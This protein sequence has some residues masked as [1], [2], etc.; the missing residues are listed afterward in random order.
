M[1]RRENPQESHSRPN[2]PDDN[3]Q[4]NHRAKPYQ[5]NH[6]KNNNNNKRKSGSV[7][8]PSQSNSSNGTMFQTSFDRS[9]PPYERHMMACESHTNIQ[10]LNLNNI[11]QFADLPPPLAV[12][13]G[14]IHMEAPHDP[15]N[16]KY[17]VQ[18][19]VY[20]PYA[21]HVYRDPKSERRMT[22]VV[23]NDAHRG[24]RERV[25]FRP[26]PGKILNSS[27]KF[28]ELIPHV[29]DD[30][31]CVKTISSDRRG[32]WCPPGYQP[33]TGN[34]YDEIVQSALASIK[35]QWNPASVAGTSYQSGPTTSGNQMPFQF[36]FTQQPAS[37]NLP[38]ATVTSQQQTTD[39]Q[40]GPSR[41]GSSVPNLPPFEDSFNV[42]R[43]TNTTPRLP[44]VPKNVVTPDEDKMIE[45]D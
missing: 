2:P 16:K 15:D 32:P 26:Q 29:L 40:Q 41:N 28:D 8:K 4:R 35:N 9:I 45:D 1:N 30:N 12:E 6:H 7:A 23:S 17:L 37:V 21:V 42:P 18:D 13:R 11:A 27:V 36:Q 31:D 20:N 43:F 44:F 39:H 3:S 14:I 25:P 5:K 24:I 22:I 34:T 10:R 33:P 19:M 38:V